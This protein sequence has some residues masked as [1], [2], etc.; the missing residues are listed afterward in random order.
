LLAAYALDR[1]G[2]VVAQQAVLGGYVRQQN[3]ALHL[4][5]ENLCMGADCAAEEAC[6][7][8]VCQPATVMTGPGDEP[9][10]L[11]L[12]TPLSGV[13]GSDGPLWRD[14]ALLA[15]E[16]V[17]MAGG[18]LGGRLI[19]PIV[20][21]DE[22]D[23]SVGESLANRL[24]NEDGVTAIW[25][26]PTS[27]SSL[28]IA[29]IAT[30]ARVPQLTCCATSSRLSEFNEALPTT[31]RFL[32][33]LA[34]SDLLEAAV[35]SLAA[36]SQSCTRLAIVHLNDDY[37][38]QFGTH[39]ETTW[40]SGGG[41]TAIRVPIP[42]EEASYTTELTSV[43]DAN[44]DCIALVAFSRTAATVLRDWEALNATPDI[45]WIGGYGLHTPSLVDDTGD[46]ALVDGFLSVAPLLEPPTPEY[47][48]FR[49]AYLA[50]YEREPIPFASHSYDAMALL[51]LAIE[52]AG[53]TD[54][55]AIRDALLQVSSRPGMRLT[56]GALGQ[57]LVEIRTG[58][59]VDYAGASGDADFDDLHRVVAPYEIWRYDAPG[60]PACSDSMAL[61]TGSYCRIELLT[62]DEISF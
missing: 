33:T 27:S 61:P 5:I 58:A 25:G 35:I 43:R 36:S 34:P 4:V 45:T 47:N 2:G 15:I 51:T 40:E 62:P 37:G 7:T 10:R 14:A 54:G 19:E 52:L 6:F 11:G 31:D 53:T 12:I 9:I 41:T 39:I 48:A 60:T 32:F 57:G 50:R 46:P 13:L 49:D 42:S 59:G 18:V 56:P 8:G 16:E 26:A 28:S 1:S 21:D 24:I 30:P 3:V 17:N 23:A 20:V 55:D 29:S 22:T 44:P 38:A